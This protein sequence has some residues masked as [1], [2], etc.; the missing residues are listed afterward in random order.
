M[1]VSPAAVCARNLHIP[2]QL[3]LL[4]AICVCMHTLGYVHVAIYDSSGVQQR[5]ECN[6]APQEA[7][8]K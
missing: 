3:V 4:S 1:Y 5:N 8:L 6:E 7:L 2:T